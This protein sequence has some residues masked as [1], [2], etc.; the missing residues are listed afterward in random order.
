MRA[1]RKVVDM[2]GWYKERPAIALLTVHLPVPH[3]GGMGAVVSQEM[4]ERYYREEGESRLAAVKKILDAA[5]ARYE[6]HVFVGPI[7]ETIVEESKKLGCDMICMGTRGAGAMANMLLGSIAT[8][9]LQLSTV[10]VT[11]VS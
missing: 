7:A 3:F 1:A 6:S 10:P 4:I 8:R 2:L 11:L 5:G 9:V